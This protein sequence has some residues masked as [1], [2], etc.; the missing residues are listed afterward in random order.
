MEIVNK[1]AQSK[2]EV[3]DLEDY[4]P[5]ASVVEMDISIWLEEGFILKEKDF[6]CAESTSIK[7]ASS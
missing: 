3:F 4:F 2:L 6:I 1:V 7:S 5:K